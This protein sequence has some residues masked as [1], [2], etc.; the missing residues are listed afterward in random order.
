MPIRAA[1]KA[2]YPPNWKEIRVSILDR[3]G[4]SCEGSPAYPECRAANGEPHPITGSKVVLTIAHLTHDERVSDPDLLAAMCQRCH[5]TYDAKHHAANASKLGERGSPAAIC[6]S[7]TKER[8]AR[9]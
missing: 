5:L 2:L 6:L 7:P 3:A 1:R 8:P 4:N 9:S